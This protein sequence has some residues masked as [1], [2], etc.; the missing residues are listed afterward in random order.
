MDRI[1]V[2]CLTGETNKAAITTADGAVIPGVSEIAIT[3]RADE[4]V[5]AT[6]ELSGLALMAEAES[7][8]IVMTD[9][10][11]RTMF[12]GRSFDDPDEFLEA[13]QEQRK[14]DAKRE[15]GA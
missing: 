11:L 1:R 14:S 15:M 3:M 9:E 12:S 2:V 5:R 10:Q 6:A 8:L 7:N 13:L 4:M